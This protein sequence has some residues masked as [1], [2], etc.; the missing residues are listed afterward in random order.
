MRWFED[1]NTQLHV[2]TLKTTSHLRFVRGI[3]QALL[4][5]GRLDVFSHAFPCIGECF[6][7][8]DGGVEFTRRY[9]K[10]SC[11]LV[12]DGIF[13]GRFEHAC[14]HVKERRGL[15]A[16]GFCIVFCIA[17]TGYHPTGCASFTQRT[18]AA[19]CLCPTAGKVAFSFFYLA[20]TGKLDAESLCVWLRQCGG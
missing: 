2:L 4:W 17:R 9:G 6:C 16:T 20:V 1:K 12:R 5:R 13:M 18:R 3:D 19:G 11:H 15:H 7:R 14:R 10:A 8:K